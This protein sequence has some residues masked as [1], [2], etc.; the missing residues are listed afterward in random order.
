M[1]DLLLFTGNGTGYAYPCRVCHELNAVEA[2]NDLSKV[3]A[4]TCKECTWINEEV[5][6]RAVSP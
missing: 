4:F 6:L 1:A 5:D 2:D 3:K